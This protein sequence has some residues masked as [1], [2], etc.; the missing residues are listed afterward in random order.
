MSS[1]LINIYMYGFYTS[2]AFQRHQIRMIQSPDE[3]V[4]KEGVRDAEAGNTDE[5]QHEC[6]HTLT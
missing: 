6:S 3:E 4:M 5:L 1:I 2:R